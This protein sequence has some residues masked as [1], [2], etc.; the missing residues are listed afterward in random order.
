MTASAFLRIILCRKALTQN[1]LSLLL[2]LRLILTVVVQVAR[3]SLARTNKGLHHPTAH[4]PL[5]TAHCP[6]PY[7]PLTIRHSLP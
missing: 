5:P 2:A 4:C 7:S 6:I 1:R 3:A